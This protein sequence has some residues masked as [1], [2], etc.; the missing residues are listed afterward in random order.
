MF[1]T[2]KTASNQTKKPTNTRALGGWGDTE[3]DKNNNNKINDNNILKKN[4]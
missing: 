2:K 3:D 1:L 4:I